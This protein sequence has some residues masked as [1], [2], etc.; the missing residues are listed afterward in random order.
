MHS[1]T[2][3][4]Q[5]EDVNGVPSGP[6]LDCAY[7]ASMEFDR[8]WGPSPN[9]ISTRLMPYDLNYQTPN[10]NADVDS[11]PSP[12][13]H[14]LHLPDQPEFASSSAQNWQS[15]NLESMWQEVHISNPDT[16]SLHTPSISAVWR[17]NNQLDRVEALANSV[18]S[19]RRIGGDVATPAIGRRLTPSHV[20]VEEH[21]LHH[22][23]VHMSKELSVKDNR[24]NVFTF[25]FNLVETHLQSP[26][27][28]SLLAWAGLH[29][30]AAEQGVSEVGL[31]HYA[32]ASSRVETLLR[33]FSQYHTD[34]ARDSSAAVESNLSRMLLST[35]FILL[36]CD[37]FIGDRPAFNARMNSLKGLLSREWDL[38]WA[39]LTGMDYRLL[40]W[41]AYL[42][43]RASAWGYS[44]GD[45]DGVGW[46]TN[47]LE[48]IS[49]KETL[50]SLYLRSRSYLNEAFGDEYPSSEL[51]GDMLQD[52]TNMKFAEA[53]S[54]LSRI[55]LFGERYGKTVEDMSKTEKTR[56]V[57]ELQTI[58]V[59]LKRI[60][61]VSLHEL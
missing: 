38:F 25:L 19:P 36:Q 52:P 30:S 14:S 42:D 51:R 28:S 39:S 37:I 57:V 56:E 29:L 32:I 12:D 40:L 55:S 54:I 45:R 7:R 34:S 41:L 59:D 24:W 61:E 4:Q 16:T 8:S 33:E 20:A 60:W 49:R 3:S 31:I 1:V 27:R 58:R 15:P 48:T 50:Q 35:T 18:G 21:L 22:Y 23:K 46:S 2:V 10:W 26:L 9:W 6:F 13:A 5:P 11:L 47:L 43:V 17:T 53:M 44:G